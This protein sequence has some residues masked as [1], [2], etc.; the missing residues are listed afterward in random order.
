MG[1]AGYTLPLSGQCLEV[2]RDRDA[3]VL[4]CTPFREFCIHTVMANPY[5]AGNMN[6]NDI[7]GMYSCAR[8]HPQAAEG[9]G[10]IPLFSLPSGAT[11]YGKPYG[12]TGG[13]VRIKHQGE[14]VFFKSA[15]LAPWQKR[16]VYPQRFWY[17]QGPAIV[18]GHSAIEVRRRL[19]GT[20]N[21]SYQGRG[22]W[23]LTDSN[24]PLKQGPDW[25]APLHPANCIWTNKGVDEPLLATTHFERCG[26]K[27][28]IHYWFC[29]P[30]T[31]YRDPGYSIRLG[32]YVGL[33]L[34]HVA[35]SGVIRKPLKRCNV[36]PCQANPDCGVLLPDEADNCAANGYLPENYFEKPDP[37]TGKTPVVNPTWQFMF[38]E[39]SVFMVGD[40]MDSPRIGG[41]R[42]WFIN[43]PMQANNNPCNEY[44]YTWY[45]GATEYWRSSVM[46]QVEGQTV[47]VDFNLSSFQ[48]Y[49][50]P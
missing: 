27:P 14:E 5:G 7:G 23:V 49:A 16:P 42:H 13:E 36:F 31:A 43:R 17:A 28:Q 15:D 1:S 11:P 40:A 20:P 32:S 24:K 38:I 47:P 33:S 19:K 25:L 45:M 12:K 6:L 9:T 10:E 37:I 50:T 22:E 41:I 26:Q 8:R 34:L 3:S 46:F 35:G 18:S 44:F 48:V 29:S 4:K 2:P 30:V 21:N 39:T